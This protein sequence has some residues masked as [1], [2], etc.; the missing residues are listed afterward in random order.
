M[1]KFLDIHDP[2]RGIKNLNMSILSN[3]IEAIIKSLLTRRV[4]TRQ[5]TT[6][7]SQA[8]TELQYSSNYSI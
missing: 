6:E 2:P 8:S 5:V 1:D 7:F 4:K 3:E